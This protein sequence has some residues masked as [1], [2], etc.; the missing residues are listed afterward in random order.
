[1][2]YPPDD[3]WPWWS[4]VLVW[5]VVTSAAWAGVIAVAWHLYAAWRS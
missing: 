5:F 4:C 2:S 1:M 3:R